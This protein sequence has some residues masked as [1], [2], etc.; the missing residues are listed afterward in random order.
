VVLFAPHNLLRDPPF[1]RLDLITCRNVL[2]YLNRDVQTPCKLC[3]GVE[4]RS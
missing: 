2:I 4:P 3:R 1:S